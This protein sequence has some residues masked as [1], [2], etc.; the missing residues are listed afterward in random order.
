MLSLEPVKKLSRQMT[1]RH[2]A[3]VGGATASE[4]PQTDCSGD[5]H[6]AAADAGGAHMIPPVDQVLAQVAAHE[7]CSAGDKHT[8][9]LHTRL[10]LDDRAPGEARCLRVGQ[11]QQ[12]T[13]D[14]RQQLLCSVE[15]AVVCRDGF[16]MCPQ[17]LVV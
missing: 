4:Q 10:G 16:C 3:W 7:A 13:D 9:A 17:L 2:A 14:S 12:H 8:V 6:A 15:T 1:C 11:G 5:A